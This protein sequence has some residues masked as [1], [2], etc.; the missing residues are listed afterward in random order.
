[1]CGSTLSP[2]LIYNEFLRRIYPDSFFDG[3]ARHRSRVG[4]VGRPD[5]VAAMVSF[6]VGE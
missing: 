6:L 1:M 5:D 3:Y 4:R 2:S